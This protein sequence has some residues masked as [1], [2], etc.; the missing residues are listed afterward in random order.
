LTPALSSSTMCHAEAAT[1]CSPECPPPPRA[2][3][4]WGYRPQTAHTRSSF[5]LSQRS[6]NKHSHL[7]SR[8][9]H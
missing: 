4:P 3:P 8:G 5:P 9:T 1:R 2:P 6:F 7:S